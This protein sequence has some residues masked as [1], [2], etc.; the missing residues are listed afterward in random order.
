MGKASTQKGKT[1]SEKIL[2]TGE[3]LYLTVERT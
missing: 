1:L 2:V 3:E